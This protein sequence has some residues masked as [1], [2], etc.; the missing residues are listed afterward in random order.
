MLVLLIL[1]TGMASG[2]L[3]GLVGL[4][5]GILAAPLL[6]YGPGLLGVGGDLT[7]KEVTG[8]TMVQGFAGALSG[9]TRHQSYGFVSWRLVGYMGISVSIAALLGALLSKIVPERS[10]LA[11]FAIMALIASLLIFLP[12]RRE[13]DDKE[14][15]SPITFDRSLAVCLGAAIGFAG[16]LVGQ[17]GSFILIPTMVYVLRIPTR[18]AIGSNLGIIPLAAT[19][20]L[21]GKLVVAQVPTLLAV[22]LAGGAVPGA[23]VG[24][25]LGRRMR[26]RILRYI[27]ATIVA[28]AAIRI[29]IDVVS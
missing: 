2:F 22:A 20:G 1:A 9:L 19:A 24:A 13:E 27:L 28:L 25:L 8:L 5:G 21:V 6:L 16:G 7:V 12:G 23:Q 4:G 18:F 29:W 14:I 15:P 26:P 10:I 11:V 3:A 17:A